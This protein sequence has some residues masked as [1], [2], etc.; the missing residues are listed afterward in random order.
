MGLR[1][2]PSRLLR[3]LRASGAAKRR[4]RRKEDTPTN[5]PL[6]SAKI[7]ERARPRPLVSK[8]VEDADGLSFGK[9]KAGL[10]SLPFVC[11]NAGVSAAL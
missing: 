9:Q 7:G 6:R 11:Y 8:F 1:F 4:L 10:T 2:K 5:R 3:A